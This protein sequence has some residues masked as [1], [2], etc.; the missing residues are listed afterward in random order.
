ME[1]LGSININIR[2]FRATGGGGGGG[3]GPIPGGGG[4]PGT[5]PGPRPAPAPEPFTLRFPMLD[6]LRGITDIAGELRSF[7]TGPTVAGFS[8]LLQGGGAMATALA[9][10]GPAIAPLIPLIGGVVLVT[11][12]TV[13]ALKALQSAAE[14]TAQR[15]E[16][17]GRFHGAMVAATMQ[18]RFAALN[19][20][21][22][23]AAENGQVYAMSQ[24]AATAA[25]DATS[26][27]SVQFNKALAVGAV[28]WHR[29][30][31]LTMRL[32]YPVARI[33]GMLADFAATVTRIIDMVNIDLTEPFVR[34][35]TDPI[36]NVLNGVLGIGAGFYGPFTFLR[37]AL[38]EI[39]R[40]LGI[41][42]QNTKPATVGGVNQWFMDDMAAITR[43]PYGLVGSSRA[44][45]APVVV[46]PTNPTTRKAR[47]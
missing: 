33:V 35:V 46:S 41:I 17:V 23:E 5:G 9:A 45:E 29:L 13:S 39:M 31:E 3:G 47:R 28:A 14:K 8:G 1:D 15:V 4:Q 2:E 44:A 21:L 43:K 30:V 18:E 10:M 32:M 37:D 11:A 16:A 24:R 26:R 6:R 34:L 36:V 22:R 27:V 7:V 42:G 40:W 12:G 19:R 25:A 38:M 20:T